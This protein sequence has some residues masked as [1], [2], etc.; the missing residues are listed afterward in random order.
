MY[1]KSYQPYVQDIFTTTKKEMKQ[2]LTEKQIRGVKESMQLII[3]LSHTI[4]LEWHDIMPEFVKAQ[5]GQI[6]MRS[7]RL[8]E[9]ATA[10]KKLCETLVYCTES[11]D[12][13]AF[14][15]AYEILRLNKFF[16]TVE[17]N[18]L[19]EFNDKNESLPKVDFKEIKNENKS[20][21]S[22]CIQGTEH[23]GSNA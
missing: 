3:S 13:M 19:K 4:S 1:R 17:Y 23:I 10:I 20:S 11:E 9:D 14:E 22:E 2:K 8:L 12:H 7:K 21:N 18:T 15:F 16:T 5:V 6:K